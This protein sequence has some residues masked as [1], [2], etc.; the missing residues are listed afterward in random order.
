[1]TMDRK[2]DRPTL[3]AIAFNSEIIRILHEKGIITKDEKDEVY[4]TVEMLVNEEE[5]KQGLK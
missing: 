5:F 4:R 1:M 3:T 2:I